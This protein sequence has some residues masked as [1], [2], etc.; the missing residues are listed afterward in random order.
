MTDEDKRRQKGDL[1]LR[2]HEAERNLAHLKLKAK[3]FSD[4]LKT[5]SEWM[6]E[7]S[8][9]GG[10]GDYYVKRANETLDK[11]L[12]GEAVSM[13]GLTSLADEINA[14]RLEVNELSKLKGE[15]GL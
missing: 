15:I 5:L 11:A 7:C 13:D 3:N 6:K 2:F 12:Q 1:L 10:T 14:A 4:F 8:G 9:G